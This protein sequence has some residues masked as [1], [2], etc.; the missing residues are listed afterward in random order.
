MGLHALIPCCL[1]TAPQAVV[2]PHPRRQTFSSGADLL[3]ATTE[4]SATTVYW[5]K[6]D[7]PIYGREKSDLFELHIDTGSHKMVDWLPIHGEAAGA[8]GHQA[9]A[10]R[11]AN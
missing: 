11:C 2:I 3:T 4:T 5:E 10:L 1:T 7:V 6:V 9:F 8:V